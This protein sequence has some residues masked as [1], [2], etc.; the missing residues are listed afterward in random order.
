MSITVDTTKVYQKVFS[1]RE[2]YGENNFSPAV[3]FTLKLYIP[4]TMTGDEIGAHLVESRVVPTQAKLR[5]QGY[6]KFKA[7][8]KE[9]VMTLAP[10]GTRAAQESFEEKFAK[11][12]RS[13]QVAALKVLA[14][15][16]GGLKAEEIEELLDED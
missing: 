1:V 5:N 15:K 10:L 8:P 2:K 14:A 6:E 11:M 7:L 4:D 16:A 12:S 13:E 3:N 9:I